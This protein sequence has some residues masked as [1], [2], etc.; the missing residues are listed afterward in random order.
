MT[1]KTHKTIL[2]FAGAV[3]IATFAISTLVTLPVLHFAVVGKLTVNPV[4]MKAALTLPVIASLALFPFFLYADWVNDRLSAL[5]RSARD[6]SMEEMV[7]K[8]IRERLGE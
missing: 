5:R 3:L 6:E 1:L 8:A 2:N 4:A 7:R